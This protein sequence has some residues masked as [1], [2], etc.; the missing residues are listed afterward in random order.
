M[1]YFAQD[2][3]FSYDLN[4][5]FAADFKELYMQIRVLLTTFIK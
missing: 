3:G 1:R 2:Y 4:I 5:G